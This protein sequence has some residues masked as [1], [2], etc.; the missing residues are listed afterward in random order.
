MNKERYIGFKTFSEME[1]LK[2]ELKKTKK[3]NLIGY[4]WNSKDKHFFEIELKGGLKE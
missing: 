3:F 1:D 4:G 2:E